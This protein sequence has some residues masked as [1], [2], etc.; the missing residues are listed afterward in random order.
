M[1]CIINLEKTEEVMAAVVVAA[2]AA[3]KEQPVFQR[4]ARAEMTG[5]SREEDEGCEELK[6]RD[7]GT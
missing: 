2:A 3:K 6:S 1:I 5:S 7:F 4:T